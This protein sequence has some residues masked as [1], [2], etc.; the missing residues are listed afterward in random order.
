MRERL[1]QIVPARAGWSHALRAGETLRIIDLEGRQ[2]VD[3]LFYALPG[4]SER[5]SA[6]ATVLAAGTPY[7]GLGTR[8]VSDRGRTLATIVAD[9][10]GNHDTVAGCC[11]C[12]SNTVRFGH[13]TRYMH[14]C[15]E[16]FITEL[17]RHGMSKRDIVANVNFFMNVPITPAGELVVS[18]G[19]SAPGNFVDIGCETDL[20]AVLSNCPQLN[21]PCNGFVPTPVRVVITAG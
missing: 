14:A 17:A 8:L 1:D 12:E 15:R 21:N 18:D 3:A 5:Y 13:E 2:A 20:L 4:T 7:L 16:N 9:T 10:C 6:Q 19:L 11:S